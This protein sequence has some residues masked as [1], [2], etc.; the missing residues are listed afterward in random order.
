MTELSP[1]AQVILAAWCDAHGW[2]NVDIPPAVFHGLAAALRALA[3]A[4]VPEENNIVTSTDFR[5]QRKHT[6]FLIL[7]IATELENH[8]H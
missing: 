3:D 4:V 1:A 8:E 2:E 7:S 6:R 5:L